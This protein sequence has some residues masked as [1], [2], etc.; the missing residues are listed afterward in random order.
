[1]GGSHGRPSRTL[2]VLWHEAHA[3][4]VLVLARLPVEVLTV[5]CAARLV[6]RVEQSASDGQSDCCGREAA[7]R[8]D[9]GRQVATA[10]IDLESGGHLT[11]A[12]G[13]PVLA[14]HL[15]LPLLVPRMVPAATEHE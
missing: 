11:R 7:D 6:I 3:F 13:V 4:L 9:H 1:M 2:V 8:T 10:E 14:D 15:E 12:E 5:D